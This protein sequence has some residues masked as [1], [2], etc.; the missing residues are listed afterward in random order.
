MQAFHY[1]AIVGAIYEKSDMDLPGNVIADPAS[2]VIISLAHFVK[3][4]FSKYTPQMIFWLLS[5]PARRIKN[6]H[7]LLLPGNRL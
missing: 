3:S 6:H 7:I 4:I 2:P 5:D 1:I